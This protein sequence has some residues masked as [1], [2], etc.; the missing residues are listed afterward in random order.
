MS[1][2]PGGCVTTRW[3]KRGLLLPFSVVTPQPLL[4]ASFRR[5]AVTMKAQLLFRTPKAVAHHEDG[6][7]N[8][9]RQSRLETTVQLY[10][11][12]ESLLFGVMNRSF[13]LHSPSSKSF[14]VQN[15]S[16]TTSKT[17][18][19]PCPI[20]DRKLCHLRQTTRL[21]ASFCLSIECFQ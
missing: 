6:S 16:W 8:R 2:S 1:Q 3:F 4:P 15:A 10:K 13:P 11:S 18:V 20:F 9:G 19:R 12:A 21:G 7:R 14:S 5:T 17:K